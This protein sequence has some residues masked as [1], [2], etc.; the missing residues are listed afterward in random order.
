M[1]RSRRIE[2]NHKSVSVNSIDNCVISMW[3]INL[4]IFQDLLPAEIQYVGDKS[5]SLA[6]YSLF[7]RRPYQ[8]A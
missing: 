4:M 8:S 7:R 5:S 6:E 2:L 3:I 1:L